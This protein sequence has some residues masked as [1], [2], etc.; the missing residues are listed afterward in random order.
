[1]PYSY[2]YK[3]I[4]LIFFQSPKKEHVLKNDRVKLTK[5]QSLRQPDKQDNVNTNKEFSGHW[6]YSVWHCNG[7]Y[8]KLYICQYPQNLKA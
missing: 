2:A 3:G 7:G 5:Y 4:G 6:K 1:M 8:T